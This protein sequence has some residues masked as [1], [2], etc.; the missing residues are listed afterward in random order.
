MNERPSLSV[1]S[2]TGE[3]VERLSDYADELESKRD[4]LRKVLKHL[5]H[6]AKASGCE[7]GLALVAAEEALSGI[8]EEW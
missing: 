1:C 5:Y 3:Y 7:M 8:Q 2:T 4:R 6:N